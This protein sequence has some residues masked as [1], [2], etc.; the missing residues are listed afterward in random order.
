MP[1]R[2]KRGRVVE[3]GWIL[4]FQFLMLPLTLTCTKLLDYL[5]FD[6]HARFQ[7]S[8]KKGGGS[9]RRRDGN[10]AQQGRESRGL[11]PLAAVG[12]LAYIL[13]L[14]PILS[15]KEELLLIGSEYIIMLH[16]ALTRM[17][18]PRT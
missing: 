8:S 13:K 15:R 5:D 18:Q 11:R 3:S 12:V 7:H 6:H 16:L 1:F 17:V 14:I 2:T 9:D 10:S 4:Q